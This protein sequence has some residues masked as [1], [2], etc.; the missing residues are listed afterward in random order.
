[1]HASEPASSP[2][3]GIPD[4]QLLMRSE[5]PDLVTAILEFLAQADPK[6]PSPPPPSGLP[7]T[8]YK[9]QIDRGTLSYKT[10]QECRQL[11]Q[12]ALHRLLAQTDVALPPRFQLAELLTELYERGTPSGREALLDVIAEAPLRFGL[13]GGLKR[14]Y[15]LAEERLDAEIFGAL[16]WRVDTEV[17]ARGKRGVSVGT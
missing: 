3:I 1:M 14:I 13:W 8:N 16:A 11:R 7:L 17:A 10:K 4:R 6:A 2:P 15:K 5:S 12:E 9:H